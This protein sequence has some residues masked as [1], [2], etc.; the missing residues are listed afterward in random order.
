[1]DLISYAF[2]SILVNGTPSTTFTPSC[3]VRQ[4]DLLSPFLFILM[5]E[6]LG[7]MLKAAL[8]SN[9]LRGISIHGAPSNVYQQFVDD[10]LIFCHPSVQEA[11]TLK[12][13]LNTFSKASGTSINLAKS[14]LFFDNTSIFI[15]NNIS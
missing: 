7:R 3:G 2:Y 15:Q 11:R 14:Q 5:S 8:I 10:N 1:M 4:G 9:S 6:G 13:I 12:S